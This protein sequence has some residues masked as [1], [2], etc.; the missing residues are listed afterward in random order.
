MSRFSGDSREIN[1]EKPHKIAEEGGESSVVDRRIAKSAALTATVLM[2]P[3]SV[4]VMT[5][6]ISE[7][8]E[9]I[10]WQGG[11]S[12]AARGGGITR[13]RSRTCR[14]AV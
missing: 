8:T 12:D 1:H 11:G 14:S 10:S 3:A 9:K 6:S 4:L 2:C 7:G 13:L 5:K